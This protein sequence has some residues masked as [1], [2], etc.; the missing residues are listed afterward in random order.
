MTDIFISCVPEDEA[1]ARQLGEALEAVGFTVWPNPALTEQSPSPAKIEK[2]LKTA[3]CVLVLWSEYS[4][5]SEKL[6][7]E[8]GEA[9]RLGRLLQVRLDR[10][11][12]P[13]QFRALPCVEMAGWHCDADGAAFQQLVERI[14]VYALPLR[15]PTQARFRMPPLP[16]LP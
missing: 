6:M 9:Q 2:A 7:A 13:F 4:I 16:T 11:P 3:R 14:N 1:E 15:R 12:L 8:A 5:A 10:V